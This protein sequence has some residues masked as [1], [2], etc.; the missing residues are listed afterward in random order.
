ML[1]LREYSIPVAATLMLHL[2]LLVWLTSDFAMKQRKFEI[3]EHKFIQANLVKL[4]PQSAP[5]PPVPVQP[6]PEPEKVE[7][8]PQEEVKLPEPEEVK[9]KIEPKPKPVVPDPKI[10]QQKKAAL[11]KALRLKKEK[12]ELEKKR[13][14]QL[15]KE[16]LEKE[17]LAKEQLERQKLEQ[18]KLKAQQRRREELLKNLGEKEVVEDAQA[19]EVTAQSYIAFIQ[20]A[21]QSNWSRPASA[22]NGMQVLL[23]IQLI[24]SGDVVSVTVA[25][26]SGNDA[27]DRSAVA[28]V[29]KAENFPELAELEPRV[30]EKY[31]R[32]FTLLFKPEDLRL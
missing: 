21:V 16:R 12:A 32:H 28:A 17:R 26:S 31:Y 29:K 22:R 5:V 14:E 3:K 15:E 13:K 11:E 8:K 7:A 2:V 9:P 19:D 18:Q 10:E 23:N 20:R 6:A 30:F 25:K 24:P 4:K 27:F 1:W